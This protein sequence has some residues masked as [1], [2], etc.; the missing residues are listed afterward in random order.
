VQIFVVDSER[1]LNLKRITVADGNATDT[2]GGGVLNN[3][4]VNATY[5]TFRAKEP[6]NKSSD[7][8]LCNV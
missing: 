1:T 4:T 5:V 7:F 3:G 2:N 6:L 8:S